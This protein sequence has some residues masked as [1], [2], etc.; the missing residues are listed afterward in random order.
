MPHRTPTALV[1]AALLA[2][3]AAA[4][5]APVVDPAWLVVDSAARSVSFDVIAGLTTANGSLNFNGFKGGALTLV[6]PKGWT[7]VLRYTNRDRN[8]PHS[9]QVIPA[10]GAPPMGPGTT[11]FPGAAS[12]DLAAGVPSTHPMEPIRFVASTPGEYRI[13]CAVPGHGMAGMWIRLR[14]ADGGVPTVLAQ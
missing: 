9:V 4:Q 10:Q 14:V 5:T 3:P 1:L 7:V 6:V 13:F 2:A 8:L 11:A 12:T